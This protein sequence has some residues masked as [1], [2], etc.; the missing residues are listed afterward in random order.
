M[1]FPME[2]YI[3][4]EDTTRHLHVEQPTPIKQILKQFNISSSSVILVRN[5]DICLEDELVED[6]DHIKLLSVVSGG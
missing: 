2:L 4:R 3:E 1:Q 5:G 6:R